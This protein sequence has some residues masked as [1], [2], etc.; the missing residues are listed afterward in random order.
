[1]FISVDVQRR[2]LIWD[3][4]WTI[5]CVYLLVC[6]YRLKFVCVWEKCGKPTSESGTTITSVQFFQEFWPSV[7]RFNKWLSGAHNL[8][9][10]ECPVNRDAYLTGSTSLQHLCY[11]L[12]SC[13]AIQSLSVAGLSVQTASIIR[14]IGQ[15]AAYQTLLLMIMKDEALLSPSVFFFKALAKYPLT[16]KCSCHN[17]FLQI[18]P[19]VS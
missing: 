12:H 11:K 6:M 18:S 4:M 1:M 5:G 13:Q 19:G 7:Q 8:T 15:S 10:H 17:I 14:T 16:C 9:A 3:K 2:L